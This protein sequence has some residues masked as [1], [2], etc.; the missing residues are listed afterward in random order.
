M[1]SPASVAVNEALKS[2]PF[3][4]IDG[5]FNFR[6]VGN[7]YAAGTGA[8]SSD[9]K[10]L[11][12]KPSYLYRCAEPSHITP[13]GKEQLKELGVKK[14]FDFRSE[15]EIEKYKMGPMDVEGVEVVRCPVSEEEKYD[16]VSL[17]KRWVPLCSSSSSL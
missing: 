3:L 6:D 9:S 7:H 12:V 14:V 8:E 1:A 15:V 10:P 2:P 11:F 4:I 5:L 17:A 16:P 13:K